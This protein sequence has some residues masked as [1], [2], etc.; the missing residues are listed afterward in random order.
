MFILMT[1]MTTP[2]STLAIYF[3]ESNTDVT[4]CRPQQFSGAPRWVVLVT[5]WSPGG[6]TGYITPGTDNTTALLQ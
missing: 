1:V 6:H 2:S 4:E 5:S 3:I